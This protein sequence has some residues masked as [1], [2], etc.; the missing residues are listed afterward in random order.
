MDIP[1]TTNNVD[2][3]IMN[4]ETFISIPPQLQPMS[5]SKPLS[6]P[7]ATTIE[8]NTKD[9]SHPDIS[10]HTFDVVSNVNTRVV[11][12]HESSFPLPPPFV[13]SIPSAIVPYNSPTFQGVLQ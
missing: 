4:I 11:P 9:I 5:T 3:H 10:E 2:S 1:E 7:I 12:P 8:F 13:S 6:P